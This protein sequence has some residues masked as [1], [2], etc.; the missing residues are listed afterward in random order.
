ME[1]VSRTVARTPPSTHAGGQDDGSYTNSLKREGPIWSPLKGHLWIRLISK[2]LHHL[3]R[4]DIPLGIPKGMSSLLRWCR[5]LLIN[6]IQRW[7][8]KGLHMGPSRLR[9]FV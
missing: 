5:I 7:P 4:E 3:K 8:F 1:V 6:R 9:E 2:I